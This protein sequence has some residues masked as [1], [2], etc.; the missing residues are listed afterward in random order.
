MKR[1]IVIWAVLLVFGFGL[2][3]YHMGPPPPAQ[4]HSQ[5]TQQQSS[6][7]KTYLECKLMVMA[8]LKEKY[9]T[10][11]ASSELTAKAIE[12]TCDSLRPREPVPVY[13]VPGKNG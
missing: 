10:Y 6:M 8:H 2:V 1:F 3:A 12:N 9:P 13:I 7:P 5:S 11:Y 4:Q